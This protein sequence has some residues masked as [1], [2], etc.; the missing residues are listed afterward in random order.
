[1]GLSEF[2]AKAVEIVGLYRAPPEN[3]VVLSVDER[4]SAVTADRYDMVETMAGE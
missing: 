2:A 4:L 1:M 3:P